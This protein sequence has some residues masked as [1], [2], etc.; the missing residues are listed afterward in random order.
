MKH[1]R[2]RAVRRERRKMMVTTATHRKADAKGK[3]GKMRK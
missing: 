2:L 3:G 1:K